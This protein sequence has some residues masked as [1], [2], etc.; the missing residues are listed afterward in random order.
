MNELCYNRWY[1]N[2]S[3]HFD[4]NEFVPSPGLWNGDE[5]S[6]TLSMNVSESI[7]N[8]KVYCKFKAYGIDG[9][10]LISETATLIVISGTIILN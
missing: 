1:V 7:N 5:L 4:R 6:V 8:T 10:R 9:G 3:Y 2:Q